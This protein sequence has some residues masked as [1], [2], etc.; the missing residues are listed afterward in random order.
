MSRYSVIP[1]TVCFNNKIFCIPIVFQNIDTLAVEETSG[2]TCM[3]TLG[4][5]IGHYLIVSAKTEKW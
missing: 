2:F 3:I 4:S 1:L 5:G